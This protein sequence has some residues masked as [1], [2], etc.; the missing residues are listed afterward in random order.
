M[1]LE[2]LDHPKTLEFAAQLEVELPTAIGHLELFWAFVA[3][4]TP[5]GDIGK[6]SDGVIASA[7][8]W[9]GKA[10]QFVQALITAGFVDT[11]EEHRLLVHD[12]AEHCPNWVRAKLKKDGTEFA[13]KRRLKSALKTPPY[14]DTNEGTKEPSIEASSRADLNQAKPSLAKGREASAREVDP[15][16]TFDEMDSWTWCEQRI[17]AVYPTSVFD[18]QWVSV[19]KQLDRIV[20]E[21]LATRE[22]LE[23]LTSQFAQQQAA[24][25]NT[26]TQF[27]GSPVKHFHPTDGKWRGPFPIPAKPENAMQRLMRLNGGTPND[28]TRVIDHDAAASIAR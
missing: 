1:K 17:R 3:K 28:D 6:W 16:E 14:D 26:G 23:A 15:R 12:W 22:Q 2:A 24:L 11:D 21:R 13:L 19:S 25:G 27:V 10:Q 9:R 5:R 8:M 7:C 18:S 4:K 20:E